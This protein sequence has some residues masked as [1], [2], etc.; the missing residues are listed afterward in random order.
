MFLLLLKATVLTFLLLLKETTLITKLIPTILTTPT[1]TL[2]ISS[3]MILLGLEDL[4]DPEGHPAT[5]VDKGQSVA[6]QAALI[7]LQKTRLCRSNLKQAMRKIAGID[8]G[9]QFHANKILT[10][11]EPIR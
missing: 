11:R 2:V 3:G 9:Y 6:R 10:V 8:V 4:Q 7:L 5:A 1:E